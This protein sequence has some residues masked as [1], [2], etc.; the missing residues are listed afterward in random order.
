M[1]RSFLAIVLTISMILGFTSC[2]NSTVGMKIK[3]G[4]IDTSISEHTVNKYSIKHTTDF[5]NEKIEDDYTHGAIILNIISDNTRNYDIYYASALDCTETGE[6]EDVVSSIDW[7]IQNNVDIICMSFATLNNDSN[8][9][10]K[11]SKAIE[12]GITIVSACINHSEQ[13]CYPAMYEGVISVSEG[14]NPNATITIKDKKFYI[15]INGDVVEWNGCS[16]LT[17]YVC[18]S[19]ANELSNGKEDVFIIINLTVSLY[20]T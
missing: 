19:I 3:I 12:A 8:L 14:A 2:A 7:C 1:K 15:K 10:E 13:V 4:V 6:I 16:A 9:Q 5:V 20:Q 18:G 17:A 11:V